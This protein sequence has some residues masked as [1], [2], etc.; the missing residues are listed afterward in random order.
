M[1]IS[2]HKQIQSATIIQKHWRRYVTRRNFK[3]ILKKH[4][5]KVFVALELLNSEKT[6]CKNLQ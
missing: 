1:S 6:Y 5:K 4:K 3:K 2:Q